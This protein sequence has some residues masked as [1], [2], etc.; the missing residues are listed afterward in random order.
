MSES[1]AEWQTSKQIIDGLLGKCVNLW[2]TL[3]KEQNEEKRTA[4]LQQIRSGL[5]ISSRFLRVLRMDDDVRQAAENKLLLE[6]SQAQIKELERKIGGQ[7]ASES[8]E[9]S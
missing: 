6:Q 3:D 5:A 8:K 9:T 1:K 7:D 4:I 2:L